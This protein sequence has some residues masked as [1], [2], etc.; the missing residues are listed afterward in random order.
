M[1]EIIILL[2]LIIVNGLFVMSEIALVSARKGRLESM[3][4]KGDIQ[5]KAALDLAENPEN[6]LSTAQI[7]ITLISILTGV[8]SGDKFSKDLTPFVEKIELLKPY[9][10]TISTVLIV[11]MVTFLSIIIGELVP[12]RLGMLRAEKIARL[13]AAPMNF[14]SAITYPIIWLL[15]KISSLIFKLFNIKPSS[16]NAVTEEEIKAM[17]TEGS[18]HGTIEEEEK[19]II[20]RVFHLGDRKITGLMTHRTEIVWFDVDDTVSTI[21]EKA[22]DIIYSTYPV[23]DKT[24]DDIKGIIYIKE[25]LK[26]E[27]SVKLSELIKPALFVPE[28]NTPYQLLEKIKTTKIHSCFIVNEYGTLEG[29]ITLNDILEAI[30]GDVPQSGQ[31]EYEITERADGT[32]LVD[33]QITF[34]DFLSHFEKT[35]WMNEDE[36]QFDTVA[37]FVLHELERIPQTGDTFDWRGFS[38]EIVD[39]DGQRI[40]KLIVK[41]PE[42]VKEDMEDDE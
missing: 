13:V 42:D 41:V 1:A 36:H 40:D 10:A 37:G 5:A 33:A 24:V 6:F 23:C 14:L 29:M 27:E 3:A 31:E 28:N 4:N 39:M 30:V 20:E 9:A 17:I 8:Y 34:Y 12:K 18:E 16:D 22:G 21:I 19:E 11:I 32:Y 25:L 38:F 26:A 15:N 35:E 2:V 7:G